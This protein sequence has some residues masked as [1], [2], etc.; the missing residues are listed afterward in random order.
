MAE[1]NIL[2]SL[3]LIYCTLTAI[4]VVTLADAD[5]CCKSFQLLYALIIMT[6]NPKYVLIRFLI[7]N[8][9]IL[10]TPS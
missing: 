7:F 5:A 1:Y 4:V 9:N 10:Y 6:F 3:L 2:T 8:Y